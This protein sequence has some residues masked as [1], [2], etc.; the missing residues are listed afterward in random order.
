[1]TAQLAAASTLVALAEEGC[2]L[3]AAGRL[4]ELEA[5]GDAWD[6]AVLD[7]GPLH[8]LRAGGDQVTALVARAAALQ[9]EQA[10]ILAAA[11]AEVGAELERLRATRRG[12][13]GYAGA[14]APRPVASL[15]TSA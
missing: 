2:A 11:R 8:A 5:Q 14:V 3:A 1:M 13:Q 9:G 15:D 7:L 12:A 4:E 6:Q 10:A